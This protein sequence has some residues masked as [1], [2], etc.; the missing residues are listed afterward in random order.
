MMFTLKTSISRNL[1][2]MATV[3]GNLYKHNSLSRII[4]GASN[5]SIMSSLLCK[6]TEDELPMIFDASRFSH[7]KTHQLYIDGSVENDL[8]MNKLSE[9]FNV[10]HFTICQLN[11]HVIPFLQRTNTASKAIQMTNF[12]MPLAETE[13]QHRFAQVL[14][15]PTEKLIGDAIQR[16]ERATWSNKFLN[17]PIY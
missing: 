5:H 4:S 7:A 9:L 2:D 12:S 17:K 14:S 6:K 10:N 15:N 13:I 1:G 8:P 16:A 3:R 11:P